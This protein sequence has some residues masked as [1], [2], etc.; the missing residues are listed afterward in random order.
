MICINLFIQLKS[1]KMIE[2]RNYDSMDL[3]ID[4]IQVYLMSGKRTPQ[5]PKE[6]QL[7]KEIREIEAKG[8]VVE[9]LSNG[10]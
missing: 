4:Q 8:R 2:E 1:V 7:L 3:D 5:N 9:V 6:R 10:I